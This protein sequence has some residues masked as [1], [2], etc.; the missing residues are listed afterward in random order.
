M[1]KYIV[2]LLA[3]LAAIPASAAYQGKLDVGT[4]D[5]AAIAFRELHDG[6]WLVGAQQQLWHLQNTVTN[7]EVFHV[8]GFWATRL[9]GQDTAYGPSL[10][11]NIGEAAGA[12]INKLEVLAPGIQQI[13]VALPPWVMK[14]SAWTS[15]EVYGGYRPVT[16]A[17]DHHWIYGVGGKVTIP[18]SM[19]YAWA[20]GTKDPNHIQDNKGL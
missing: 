6:M 11:V 7:R 1:K 3:V 8:A 14:L 16:G 18:M 2:S 5:P 19:L 12:A 13:G 15:L 20:A 10:G 17:D 9:E 4:S